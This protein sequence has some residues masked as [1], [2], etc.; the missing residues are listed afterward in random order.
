MPRLG[1]DES[2]QVLWLKDIFNL[3]IFGEQP[4]ALAGLVLSTTSPVLSALL[5]MLLPDSNKPVLWLNYLISRKMVSTAFA[6]PL[7]LCLSFPVPSSG[8]Q[9]QTYVGDVEVKGSQLISLHP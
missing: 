4:L 9:V 2:R 8:H 1:Q 6:S 5:S 3:F 7:H